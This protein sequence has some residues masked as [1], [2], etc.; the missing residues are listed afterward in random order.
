MR[1][2]EAYSVL[3]IPAKRAA[4][5]RDTLRL[6]PHSAHSRHHGHSSS[7]SPSYSSTNPAGGRPPS[8]LSRRRGTFQGPPPSFFRSGGWGSHGAK[9]R[10]AHDDSTGTTSSAGGMGPGQSP[11][12]HESTTPDE[13]AAETLRHFDRA[14]HERTG[15]QSDRRRAARQESSDG[16]RTNV[17]VERG[18][19]GMFFVIGGVIALSVLV[20]FGVGG[21]VRDSVS[22]SSGGNSGN[23]VGGNGANG[24][25]GER[26]G[27]RARKPP[28]PPPPS[29][30]PTDGVAAL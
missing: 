11:H 8:G 30:S 9:R 23:G 27:G 14:S 18:V 12:R 6:S 22:V 5:D 28:P 25:N 16:H 17:E 24:G 15:R 26:K 19:A 13:A 2:S 20:P 4:Y 3:S 1:I 7:S 29:P 21:M 10:A